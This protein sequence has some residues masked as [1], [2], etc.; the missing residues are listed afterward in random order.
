MTANPAK[1]YSRKLYAVH[2]GA[3]LKGALWTLPSLVPTMLFSVVRLTFSLPDWLSVCIPW[4]WRLLTIPFVLGFVRTAFLCYRT[5]SAEAADPLFYFRSLRRWGKALLLGLFTSLLPVIWM[6]GMDGLLQTLTGYGM[7]VWGFIILL[8]FSVCVAMLL[9]A[10]FFFACYLYISDTDASA[11]HL[12]DRSLSLS[13]GHTLFM[14]GYGIPLFLLSGAVTAF[15]PLIFE[16][17]AAG[18]AV[19]ADSLIRTGGV[20]V[21]VLLNWLL[22]PYLELCFS[23]LAH[24]LLP[25]QPKTKKVKSKGSEI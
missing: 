16:P 25:D 19:A 9:W 23:G 5:Q 4:L 18:Q 15:P 6:E 20:L 10:R 1:A 17:L 8:V 11:I 3:L 7:P 22:T 24:S 2:R 21:S 12:L 13:K 14:L